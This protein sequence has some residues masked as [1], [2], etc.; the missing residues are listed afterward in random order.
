MAYVFSANGDNQLLS[1]FFFLK[2]DSVMEDPGTGSA[3]A[4]LGGWLLRQK[5]TLPT[6]YAIDQGAAVKRPCRIGLAVDQQRQI[7][8]SGRVIEIGRGIVTLP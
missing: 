2:Y 8:V 3:T 5:A 6:T 1:R 4:N 7:R